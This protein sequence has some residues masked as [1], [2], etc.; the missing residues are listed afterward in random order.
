MKKE[1]DSVSKSAAGSGTDKQDASEKNAAYSGFD[2][3]MFPLDDSPQNPQMN[4]RPFTKYRIVEMGLCVAAI[5]L[6]LLYLYTDVVKL[7]FLLPAFSAG[8]AVITALRY[9]DGREAASK[10]QSNGKV[11]KTAAYFPAVFMGFLTAVVIV[12]TIAYF[13]GAAR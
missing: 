3:N 9:L 11:G 8:M 1:N 5:V 4:P 12:V 13:T 10:N 2:E 6:G 7:G